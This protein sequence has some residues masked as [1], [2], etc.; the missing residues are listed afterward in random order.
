LLDQFVPPA[1]YAA[2]VQPVTLGL[3]GT[4]ILA[5]WLAHRQRAEAAILEIRIDAG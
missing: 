2:I 1:W 5:L 3:L 4:L